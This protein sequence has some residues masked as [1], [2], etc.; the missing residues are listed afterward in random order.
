MQNKSIL[1]FGVV[2]L[3]L[4]ATTALYSWWQHDDCAVL[5]QT[6]GSGYFLRWAEPQLILV[7]ADKQTYMASANS[8][9]SACS[10]LLEQLENTLKT[11]K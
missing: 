9:S 6:L 1:P 4:V 10:L 2:T 8:Q 11:K 7:T 3:A 5:K